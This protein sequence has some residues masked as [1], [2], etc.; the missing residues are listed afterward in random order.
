[1]FV[2]GTVRPPRDDFRDFIL[3]FAFRVY[4]NCVSQIRTTSER[5]GGPN[6][7]KSISEFILVCLVLQMVALGQWNQ[8]EREETPPTSARAS[9]YVSRKR[10]ES[11]PRTW[12]ADYVLRHD[13]FGD[14]DWQPHPAFRHDSGI[15]NV[16]FPLKKPMPTPRGF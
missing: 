16:S 15:Q 13:R 5:E 11:A 7:F 1:M 14:I 2:A 8:A 3:G 4:Y 12:E 10:A 6:M 9:H